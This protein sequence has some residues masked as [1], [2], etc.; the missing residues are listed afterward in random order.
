MNVHVTVS[1]VVHSV[2]I[3]GIREQDAFRYGL[4]WLVAHATSLPAFTKPA[5]R[6]DR[7]VMRCSH[8]SLLV[9]LLDSTG[10]VGN[11]SFRG[12][13]LEVPEHRESYGERRERGGLGEAKYSPGPVLE[14][15]VRN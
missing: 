1:F 13:V 6:R 7:N 9:Q 2:S 10:R 11:I 12:N 4:P 8:M 3:R 5:T 15:I 14:F